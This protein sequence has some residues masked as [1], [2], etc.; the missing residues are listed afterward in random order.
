MTLR[1]QHV[2]I[3]FYEDPAD[4]TV[5]VEQGDE[6]SGIPSA[7]D[8]CL[9]VNGK[10]D[11][12]VH[13]DLSTQLLLVHL[14]MLAKPG[15][16]DVFVFGLGSGISA[17]AMRSYPVER[18][19]IAEN[20]DPV[21]RASL[22]FTSWNRSVLN[23]PRTRLWREDARTVLKLS[24]Q[25]YDVIVAEPSNPWT[26]GIGSVF[27]REFYQLAAG[28]LK[29]G[30][31]MAQWFHVYEMH[32]GIMKLVLRTFC[33]VFPH[34]EIWDSC[35]G[36]IILLGS[37]DPWPTGPGI[38]RQGFTLP[39]VRSDL[40]QIGIH[41]P[42]ALLARQLASQRTA[43]AITGDGPIQ[44]DL[45]PVL[46]YAAPQALYIGETSQILGQFDER[47]GQQLLAPAD[48]LAVL[49]SL[50]PEQVRSVF[51]EY[52]P[53][54]FELYQSVLDLAPSTNLPCIFNSHAPRMVIPAQPADNSANAVRLD[55]AVT[56]IGGTL[57]E[58]REGIR[59]IESIVETPPSSTDQTLAAWTSLAAT[60][61]LSIGDL[62][63]AARLSTLALKQN[64]ADPQAP[65]LLRIIARQ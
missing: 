3:L 55:R 7:S 41:S 53:V 14:P 29:P 34:V 17:G 1:K 9:R 16:R 42:E 24:P 50:P 35:S 47:A 4:A 64:P 32:D 6:N 37:F 20:C 58:R 26:V 33:S 43:F 46:E 60:A 31:I 28:R 62:Q 18:I 30:G 22:L 54:D 59:L 23:D 8:R 2:H 48:K 51:S 56:L 10:T 49:Q 61:A 12:T 15:A 44:S 57:Q 11:A 63:Q 13:G 25:R 45:F 52:K 27:S 36:D 21:V 39:G 40:A 5:S 19:V 65:F 38:F